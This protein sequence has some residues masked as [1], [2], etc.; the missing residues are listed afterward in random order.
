MASA[1]KLTVA[2]DRRNKFSEADRKAQYDAAQHRQTRLLRWRFRLYRRLQVDRRLGALRR[3]SQA[4]RCQPGSWE[5]AQ[6]G[7][8]EIPAGDWYLQR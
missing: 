6:V 4:H 5:I 3:V 7:L 8:G 2:L 1:T